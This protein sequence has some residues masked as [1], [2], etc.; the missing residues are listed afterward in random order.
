MRIIHVTDTSI[1]NYDGIST[2]V[3]ELIEVSEK[4]HDEILVLTTT[5]HGND[6]R[7]VTKRNNTNIHAF[8]C[9]R[10]PGKP[11]FIAVITKGLKKIITD[12]NPDIIWIHTIG[13]LGMQ[14]AD[15]SNQKY[16]VVYTKHCFDAELWCS[17]LN[18]PKKLQKIFYMSASFFENKIYRA[19]N[20]VVYHLND[21]SKVEKGKFYQK[22][23]HVP[24]P[25]NSRYFE[26]RKKKADIKSNKLKLGFCGRCD[27][28]KG[29][30]NTFQGLEIFQRKYK[31]V[32]FEFIL[33]GDGPEAHRLKEKYPTIKVTITGYVDDVVPYLDQLDGFILSS[34]QETISLSSLE[35]YARGV[36]I[37]SVLIGYLSENSQKLKN[38]YLF[39][40]PEQLADL[41][42]NKLV[43]KNTNSENDS[44][45]KLN[46]FVVSYEQLYKSVINKISQ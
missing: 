5:P 2:Y 4:N 38:F 45:D 27:P 19:A 29:I 28:D 13:T 32:D 1:Y 46:D 15:F 39:K 34:H 8:K 24:P 40:T 3:N 14:V 17:Y 26:N 42:Y 22:F 44:I 7:D 11:K 30:A 33:I 6:L 10:F 37:F 16:K 12:F 41:V 18:I 25:L 9:L 21:I 35:A 31:D 43:I 36:T 20:L 23:I